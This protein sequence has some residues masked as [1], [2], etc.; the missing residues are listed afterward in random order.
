MKLLCF[1]VIRALMYDRVT[2]ATSLVKYKYMT[3]IMGASTLSL[4]E[5][6]CRSR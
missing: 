5:R 3:A 4:C 1:D 2:T 6:S